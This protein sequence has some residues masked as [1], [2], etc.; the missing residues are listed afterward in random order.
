MIPQIK[1]GELLC[2]RLCHDLTGPIGAVANGVEFMSEEGAKMQ[3]QALELI[4]SSALQ[5]VSRLQFYR[6][7]YGRINDN[8]EANIEALRKVVS[9]FFT[10]SKITLDWP[11]THTDSSGVSISYKMSRLLF[12]LIIIASAALL[13]G[14]TL[15]VRLSSGDNVKAVHVKVSGRSIKWDTEIEAA[16][17]HDIGIES[18]TPK[19][20][21]A[22]MTRLLAEELDAN[23][24]WQVGEEFMEISA[25]RKM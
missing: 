6:K 22:Y 11:D 7:A 2:T 14:G 12:N 17:S 20:I 1:L 8:G 24:S 10:G 5:A 15:A 23:L 4:S 9:D 21:Q 19:I 18:L 3:E 13:R 16:L 25:L